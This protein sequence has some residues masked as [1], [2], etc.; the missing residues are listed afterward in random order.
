MNRLT[1][2]LVLAFAIVLILALVIMW[3]ALLLVLRTRPINTDSQAIELSA[4]LVEILQPLERLDTTTTE[5]QFGRR[6]AYLQIQAEERGLR[7]L[8]VNGVDCVLWDSGGA[9]PRSLQGAISREPFLS[10]R[11]TRFSK[12]QF[13]DSAT[14]QVWL[15]AEQTFELPVI[16]I[17]RVAQDA[18]GQAIVQPRIGVLVAEPLPQQTIRGVLREYAGSGLLLALIRAVVIGMGFAL[19]ASFLLVRWIARPLQQ[20]AQGA[21]QLAD[22]D[23]STRVA[24][25]GP[26]EAQVV[27]STFNDMAARVELA[28][29]AQR[30]FLAN[31]SHDLRT[32]LTSIQGFAQAIAEGV[33]DEGAARHAASIIHTEAGRMS[34]MVTDLLDL[35]RI[36]AGRLDM[37]RQAVQLDD[38]VQS[39]AASLSI[40]ATQQQVKLHWEIPQLPRVAGDGDRLAQVFTNLV[41]NAIKHTPQGGQVSIS[42]G[43]DE[44]GVW[45][46]I[47]DTGEGIPQAD[48]LRIFERFYQV[49]KSR[50]KRDGTGLGLAIV[51]EII[52]AHSGRIWVKSE[53]GQGATFYVWLPQPAHDMR[54]TVIRRRS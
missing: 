46:S 8:L 23:Y 2:R 33:A 10:R 6:I 29:Q 17:R 32:P 25:N 18:C 3:V 52:Q 43:L 34:R 4:A 54:E 53:L 38:I 40:K 16:V 50:A 47:Q 39:V 36:Q 35:A 31:V 37:M 28:Q 7:I 49:D 19:I 42:A 41:D 14:G 9:H 45:V 15:F 22:G 11:I 20:I 26:Y 13:T 1:T 21:K 51:Y 12:G 48:I 27:A 24:V 5:A 30:D 44:K